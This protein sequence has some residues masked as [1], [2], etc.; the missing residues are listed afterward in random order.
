MISPDIAKLSV[1]NS[2]HQ[3]SNNEISE[4]SN[5]CTG[6]VQRISGF[7]VGKPCDLHMLVLLFVISAH[8][9]FI[10]QERQERQFGIIFFVLILL[11]QK[12]RPV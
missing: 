3:W 6:L 2:G 11:S 5:G 7:D 10:E 12:Y 8:E 4:F 1:T 9:S